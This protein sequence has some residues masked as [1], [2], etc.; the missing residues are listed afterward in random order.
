MIYNKNITNIVGRQKSVNKFE[1]VSRTT[2]KV[3]KNKKKKSS[4]SWI[5]R[6][7][8]DPFVKQAHLDGY[9]CRSAFKLIEIDEKFKIF[10]KGLSVIDVGAAPGSW[11]QIAVKKSGKGN[12]IG[13]DL[14]PIL[15]IDG[16]ELIQ[17]DFTDINTQQIIIN[18]LNVQNK[19]YADIIMS[20]MAAN[21]TG[22]KS[23]DHLR[24]IALVES[25][26]NFSKMLLADNGT[27][28][29]KVFMGGTEN[30]LLNDLKKCFKKVKHFKPKSSRKESIENYIVATG[31]KRN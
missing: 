24:T 16:C 21:T 29:A 26:W 12:V 31:F 22:F 4:V 17:G 18:K 15:P 2:K 25:V 3:I 8:N 27:F 5:K 9:R 7:I 19:Q 28:I 23:A 1:S 10:N 13:I 20:D 11:S 30:N 6:Q 14:L